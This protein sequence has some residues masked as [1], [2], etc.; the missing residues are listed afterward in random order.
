MHFAKMNMTQTAHDNLSP[1][2]LMQRSAISKPLG[3]S[4]GQSSQDC[5]A[6]L[7]AS[8]TR[9]CCAHSPQRQSCLSGLQHASAAVTHLKLQTSNKNR[10][11]ST[12]QQEAELQ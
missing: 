6:V 9:N 12:S 5:E 4:R 11:G 10:V 2:T 3:N 1:S 8:I 7:T